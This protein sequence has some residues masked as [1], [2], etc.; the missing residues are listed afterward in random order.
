MKIWHVSD[1]HTYHGLLNVPDDID[2]VI[3]SGDCS[4]LKNPYNNEPEVRD[5]I[6]WYSLLPILV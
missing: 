3:H 1:T 2:I 6:D 4:K 5:F